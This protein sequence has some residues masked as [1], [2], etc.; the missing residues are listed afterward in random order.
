MAVAFSGDPF[1]TRRQ[2]SGLYTKAAD[3]R[4]AEQRIV[5]LGEFHR[6]IAWTR[7]QTLFELTTAEGDFWIERLAGGSERQ[8]VV[9]GLNARLSGDGQLLAY[10][11]DES[12]RDTVYVMTIGEGE[13]A[14]AARWQIAE[15]SDPVWAPGGEELYYVS[16]TRLMA[17][18]LDASAGV[19]V[20]AQR[21]V[22]DSFAVPVYGDYD[23]SPD[24]R[25]V[26]LVRP[27]DVVRGREIILAL[28]AIAPPV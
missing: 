12:G 15:G 23:V 28:D 10:V 20:V 5:T 1:W 13:G 9:R 25:S 21:T 19:R 6:P 7:D 4:T 8:R 2:D 18:Q 11:S 26:A 22:Q 17:A 16:G 3:G 27:V 24:G 14:G